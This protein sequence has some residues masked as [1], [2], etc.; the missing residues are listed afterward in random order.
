MVNVQKCMEMEHGRRVEYN[1]QLLRRGM[2]T[3]L[4]V[5]QKSVA[6][7]KGSLMPGMRESLRSDNI[8]VPLCMLVA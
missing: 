8:S 7:R 3:H 5:A 2:G 1:S 4:R 6:L